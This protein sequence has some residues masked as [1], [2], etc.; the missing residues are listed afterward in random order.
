MATRPPSK[1]K[2][3]R[4]AGE[5][6]RGLSVKTAVTSFWRGGHQF[7]QSE[8]VIALSDLTE[9]QAEQIRGEP[10]LSVKEVDIESPKAAEVQA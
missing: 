3:N 10:M 1:T 8:R 9:E 2:A 4:P 7:G 6:T 5:A